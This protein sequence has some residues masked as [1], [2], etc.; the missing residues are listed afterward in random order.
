MHGITAA[1]TPK[2]PTAVAAGAA[3]VRAMQLL[4][5][6]ELWNRRDAPLQTYSSTMQRKVALA[7]AAADPPIVVFDE[8]TLA[9]DQRAARGVEQWIAQLA[10]ERGKTVLLTTCQPSVASAIC[11]RVVVLRQ[12]R[13]V[14]DLA[15]AELRSLLR[16]NQYQIRLKGQLGSQW[17]GWSDGLTVLHPRI[18]MPRAGRTASSPALP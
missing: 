10:Y 11:D 16:D 9:L 13:L 14:A 7:R 6:L 8:P 4:H 12:E 17:S 18:T 5:E 1:R 2:L 15:A 3:K